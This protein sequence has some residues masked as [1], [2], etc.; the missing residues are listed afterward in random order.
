MVRH[1]Y[2]RCKASPGVFRVIVATDDDR[3]VQACNSFEA[4]VE[5]TS[6]SHGSGTDRVAEVA[7][8]HP[9][10]EG[11]L[12]VQGDEPG[13]EP[14]T[15]GAVAGLLSRP[16]VEIASAMTRFR[17]HES[18]GNPNAVKVVID[19]DNEALYFSRSPIPYHR[20]PASENPV[21][22]RHLGIYGFRRNV[23][24]KLTQLAPSHLERAESLEQLRWLE[25][26]YRI[27]LAEVQSRSAGIDTPADLDLYLN[28]SAIDKSSVIP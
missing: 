4:E 10:F 26:G 21:Y 18:V 19:A 1:V 23:L 25:A 22:F 2:E 14:A 17:Q 16:D 5:L 11:V 8:R 28:T 24:L 27:R 15:I 7:A 12:N 3:I 20:D 9:E 13:I 6:S